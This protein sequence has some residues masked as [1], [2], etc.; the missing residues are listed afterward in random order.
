MDL[1]GKLFWLAL[2][3]VLTFAF[4]VLFEFGP[5]NYMANARRSFDALVLEIKNPGG[6]EPDR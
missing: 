4:V 5:D 1:I 3:L 2:Y 6:D